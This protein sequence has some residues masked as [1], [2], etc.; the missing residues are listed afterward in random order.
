MP[1]TNI[2]DSDAIKSM[3]SYLS[4]VKGTDGKDIWEILAERPELAQARDADH[5]TILHHAIR[6]QSVRTVKKLLDP[7]KPWARHVDV[8]AM[9]MS[10]SLKTVS[11]PPLHM[12]AD[13]LKKDKSNLKPLM[14]IMRMLIERGA[15]VNALHQGTL[16]FACF[17][18]AYPPSF[19]KYLIERGAD[20]CISYT[21]IGDTTF[22]VMHYAS[23]REYDPGCK[24]VPLLLR[25]CNVNTPTGH[26]SGSMTP[27]KYAIRDGLVKTVRYLLAHGA[28]VDDD[29]IARAHTAV[30]AGVKGSREVL[31]MLL[32]IRSQFMLYGDHDV[33][34]SKATFYGPDVMPLEHGPKK[35]RKYFY[36]ARDVDRT[37]DKKVPQLYNYALLPP[38]MKANPL[39]RNSWMDDAG[40]NSIYLWEPVDQ[41]V[42]RAASAPSTSRLPK[43]SKASVVRRASANKK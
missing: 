20:P 11:Y 35:G 5:R 42:A 18:L 27:I 24:Y 32:N 13:L 10:H 41:R 29:A 8:N 9:A 39:S 6:E 40:R 30:D 28:A 7:S 34:V 37:A 1:A 19:I 38:K 31:K 22:T 16:L 25:P 15:D 17:V 23:E 14:Q 2:S 4:H 26:G 12:A 33:N 21:V 43:N 3:M 36:D